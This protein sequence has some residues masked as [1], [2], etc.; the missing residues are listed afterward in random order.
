MKKHKY[1]I[2]MLFLCI[3]FMIIQAY[4]HEYLLLA[5]DYTVQKGDTLNM[6]LFLAQG[7]NV[8]LERTLQ[9]NI[10][11]SFD[12]YTQN[13]KIN[14]L[15]LQ[16][17]EQIPVLNYV[18]DF[19]GEGLISMQRDYARIALPPYQFAEY[20]KE[21]GLDNIQFDAAKTQ[22][23]QREKYSRYIKA[24][25]LSGKNTN[26]DLYK[27]QIGFD[28]EIIL[29]DN[30]YILNAGDSLRVKIVFKGQ[31]LAN[32]LIKARNRK[33]D[34]NTISKEVKTNEKGEATLYLQRE[35]TWVIHLT[36]IIACTDKTDC[37]WE[38]FW[39]SYSFA[40]E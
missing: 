38:S 34:E 10:T 17:D 33:G 13:K 7:F 30:P 12:L 3:L 5:E 27:K 26:S 32:K 39:A 24:L 15:P 20:V 28:L 16:Q 31:P 37:D 1:K 19:D 40:V 21:D 11:K 35:G 2:S 8:E 22:A 29:L 25:I 18:V 36:H 4:A 6:H 14:L 9:K 23:P